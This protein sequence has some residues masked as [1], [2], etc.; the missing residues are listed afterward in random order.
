[1]MGAPIPAT[2][3]SPAS[4]DPAV[5]GSVRESLTVKGFPSLKLSKIEPMSRTGL[6]PVNGGT[7]PA[8]QPVANS[9]S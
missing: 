4:N 5:F 1:M 8:L 3:P 6:R 7:E 9:N 2:A